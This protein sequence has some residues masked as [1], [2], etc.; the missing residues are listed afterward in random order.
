VSRRDER[1][2]SHYSARYAER[3]RAA[4]RQAKPAPR[5]CNRCP[6][7]SVPGSIFCEEHL[8]EYEQMLDAGTDTTTLFAFCERTYWPE[9]R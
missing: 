3:K 2:A 1:N 9:S 8:R 4:E 5:P 7:I 6:S